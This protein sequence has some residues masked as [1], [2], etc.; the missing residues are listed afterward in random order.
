MADEFVYKPVEPL[1]RSSLLSRFACSDPLEV[2][3]ALYSAAY[4]DPDWK[5]VQ[6]WC[7]KFLKSED[8]DIRWA[9]ATCLGDLALFHKRLDLD[10]VLPALHAANNDPLIASTVQDSISYIKQAVRSQ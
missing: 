10:L 2:A 7:L 5:W 8:V 9:A 6:G 3:E 4:H 1:D